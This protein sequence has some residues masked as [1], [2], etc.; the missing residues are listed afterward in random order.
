MRKNIALFV[1]LGSLAYAN[2]LMSEQN[3]E[4]FWVWV[5]L[6][7]L[8]MIGIFI[9]FLSSKQMSNMQEMYQNM[10]KKQLEIEQKQA[11]FLANMSENI[12][13]MAQKAFEQ[14]GSVIESSEISDEFK[15]ELHGKKENLLDTT[16][17]LIDFLQLKSKKVEINHE[18]FNLNN[19]LNEI[20][21]TIGTQFSGSRVEL[22][23]DTD[24][25][26]PRWLIGDSLHLGQVLQNIL[27]H[28]M[29]ELE[30]EELRL[31]ISMFKNFENKVELQFQFID[32]GKGLSEEARENLF[33]PYYVEQEK[34]YVGL[35]LFVAKELVEMMGG[36]LSVHSQLGKGTTF[37]LSILFEQIDEQ[38]KRRYRLPKKALTDKKVCIIDNSYTA[39]LAIKKMFAYFKHDVK[40]ISRE[41][42]LET[43]PV[44]SEYDIVVINESLLS[45]QMI[46]YFKRIK[47]SKEFKVVALNSLLRLAQT[48]S[49]TDTV[50]DEIM[51]KPLNQERVFELITR[52]YTFPE[53]VR[54]ELEN[55][56]NRPKAKVIKSDI[57]ESK[58]ITPKSFTAFKGKHILIV[59]DNLINQKVLT[60]LFQVSEM[61]I[62]IANNGKEA[63]ELVKNT[64][65]VFDLVLMDINMPVMDGYTATQT[66]R[67]E[68]RFD[69]LPIVA[70]TALL[71]ETE[72]EKM[73][74]SGVNAFLSKPLNVGKL[75]T[76]M[77]S[78]LL[79]VPEVKKEKSTLPLEEERI[80][81]KGLNVAW[82]IEHANNNEAL[83]IEILK[84][85]S[86]A[87]GQ[88]AEVFATL[89][90]EHRYEQLKMLCL[91]MKGLTGSIGAEEMHAEV[92]EIYKMIIYKKHQVLSNY[93]ESYKKSLEELM[94]S[95][96]AYTW[97]SDLEEV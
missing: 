91:D 30:E 5:A 96:E 82:G 74:K 62:S 88:S 54:E 8:G 95:I 9:L 63:V 39:A 81:Y 77:S 12:F 48:E 11:L 34:A 44:L 79:E 22:I 21:G 19:V 73:F 84:E 4:N 31:K 83:Y 51:L 33:V 7:A 92:S 59:E 3:I 94:Q 35:G 61:K 97:I 41:R 72:I 45:F 60:N 13:E 43:K 55:Q 89:V 67:Y 58:N 15:K 75:Y 71:L 18:V 93:I 36:E 65:E 14:N 49:I 10:L 66:I 25:N 90:N 40:V 26:I 68:K 20:S 69:T 29:G 78:F 47:Q 2:G 27:E 57:V 23:F 76:V 70:F 56:I 37:T 17:D 50:I 24:T 46:E 53:E 86:E 6:F 52:L 42:F 32:D 16:H 87:Y 38:D 64:D 80:S 85:F 1:G 28:R